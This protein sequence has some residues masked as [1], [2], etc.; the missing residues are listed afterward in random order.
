MNVPTQPPAFFVPEVPPDTTEAEWY[1]ALA[2]LAQRPVPPVAERVY[3]ITYT[4]NGETWISTVGET[5]RDH[6]YAKVAVAEIAVL[7]RQSCVMRRQY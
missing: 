2:A 4:H 6:G 1:Q 7:R 5:S 3:S